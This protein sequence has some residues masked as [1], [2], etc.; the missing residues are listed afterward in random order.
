MIME[1]N[2]TNAWP[3]V[4]KLAEQFIPSFVQ[5]AVW[6]SRGEL[7]WSSKI[8]DAEEKGESVCF[9][10]GKS[11]R[12]EISGSFLLMMDSHDHDEEIHIWYNAESEA[13]IPDSASPEGFVLTGWLEV[14]P[15]LG[16][17]ELERLKG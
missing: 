12:P 17:E 9:Y 2:P 7:E 6:E 8:I 1:E 15:Y 11:A 5:D 3:P 13:E 14:V 16:E 10:F 4:K